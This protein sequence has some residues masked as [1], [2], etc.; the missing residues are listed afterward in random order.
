MNKEKK[1]ASLS[2]LNPKAFY[3]YIN[4]KLKTSENVSSLIKSD[5]T[6]TTNDLEKA[7]VLNDFFSSVFTTED[8]SNIPVFNSKSDVF[9]DKI[10][11]SIKEMEDALRSL[12]VNKSSGPDGLHP[13]VLKE[14][15]TVLSYPLKLLFDKTITQGKLPSQWKIAEVR[16]IFKKGIKTS[17][18]NYR[19]VSLTPIICK[20][21]EGFIKDSIFKHLIHNNLLSDDQYGFCGGRS[22]TTQLLNTINDWFSYLDKNIPVDAVYLDFRKAFDTVPHERLLNK[23]HGYGVRGQLLDWIRDFL[24]DRSQ[25][26]TINDKS[27]SKIPVTSGVPQG[28]VLGPTLFIYFINDLPSL[29]TIFI[30][31]FADDTKAYLPILSNADRI[32]LQKTIDDMVHWS[33]I[34]QLHFNGSKCKVLHLGK[35]NPCY[36]YTIEDDNV[37]KDLEVTVLEK[38]L[39]VHVDPLL[40]FENHISITVKKVR[41][42]SGLIIRSFS[43]K[44][45]DIMLPIYISKVRLILEYAN[46]VWMPYKRKHIDLIESVQRHF[47]RYIIGMKEMRYEDRLKS[48]KLYSLE[49]RRFRGDMIEVFKMCHGH[50]D[51]ITTKTLL[52]YNNKSNTR[53]NDFKLLKNRVN[54][55]QFLNFFTNRVINP[56]NKLPR[57][58]VNAGSINAFKKHIDYIYREH[59]YSTNFEIV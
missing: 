38:D 35:N 3:Q 10:N 39:G 59:L 7:E 30:K 20:V 48:L 2:K 8:V 36:K 1:V 49:Y 41:S 21:F 43:F 24:K 37:I 25:Y 47:T 13:R 33:K 26:V 57:E 40:S 11:V 46:V 56:W 44:T 23:L 54:S 42:L 19:P 4:N 14:L 31:I 51:P 28:S 12:N 29:I 45:I 52:T 5:G 34:W 15:A 18:G 6:L 58:A 55:T 50:Y 27:S 17:P 32:I 22:C 9:I 53:T 16:P